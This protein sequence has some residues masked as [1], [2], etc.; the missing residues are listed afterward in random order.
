MS[1]SHSKPAHGAGH[2]LFRLFGVDIRIHPSWLLFALFV[3][4]SLATGALPAAFEG[5]PARAYW[6][7]AVA[8]M[9]G[10]AVSVVLHEMGHTLVARARGLSVERITLFALGGV[11]EL[12]D[13]PKA[14]RDEL[15]MAVAGPLVSVVLAFFLAFCAGLLEALGAG[16]EMVGALAFL[17]SLNLTLAI[18]NMIPAFP[19]DGG[20][21]L[22]AVIWMRTGNPR[23]ATEIAARTGEWFGLALMGAG[24]LFALQGG[25]A[26]GL[27]WILIGAFVRWM[28]VSTRAEASAGEM[29]EPLKVSELM[30]RD[31]ETASGDASV[32]RFVAE[33]LLRSRHAFFPVI[34]DGRWIGAIAPEQLGGVP[35]EAWASTPIR[36]V[37]VPPERLP[38]VASHA[39]LAA[40][41][42]QMCQTGSTYL[43]VVDDG[44]L[45][46]VLNLQDV[47]RRLSIEKLLDAR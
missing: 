9:V 19:L 32:D 12:P 30:A 27:W 43:T 11:A 25:L 28:A 38:V 42:K 34:A 23:R 47:L 31:I 37:C 22:R 13:E 17:A 4:W 5:L 18:F 2:P 24:L 46:G 3:A 7:M 35:R 21:V 14:A 41:L 36:K 45:V 6:G 39:S 10:L 40:A 33:T 20:R 26:Q 16:R 29:L 1:S 8:I 15:M 44:E